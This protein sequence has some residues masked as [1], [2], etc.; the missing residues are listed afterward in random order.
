[1]HTI[2]SYFSLNWTPEYV[3]VLG[4]V[5]GFIYYGNKLWRGEI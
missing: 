2:I 1:M 4:A 3:A 5:A